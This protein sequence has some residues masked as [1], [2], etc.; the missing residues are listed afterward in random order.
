MWASV[1]P[2]TEVVGDGGIV[3]G[4]SEAAREQEVGTH[5]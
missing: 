3:S 1:S 2:C 5:G 4:Q